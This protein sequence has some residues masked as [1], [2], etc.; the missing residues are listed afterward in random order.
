MY[1]DRCMISCGKSDDALD[2][3]KIKYIKVLMYVEEF[4]EYY[5]LN[6]DNG[7]GTGIYKRKHDK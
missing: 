1:Y 6:N 7:D 4:F 5:I 3:N 2:E